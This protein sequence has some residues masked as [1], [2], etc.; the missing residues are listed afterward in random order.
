[1]NDFIYVNILNEGKIPW[2]MKQ[3]PLFYY[4]AP[5]GVYRLLARDPRVKMEITNRELSE[6][7][8]AEYLEKLNPKKEKKE[9]IAPIAEVKEEPIINSFGEEVV[10]DENDAEID[11]ILA[12]APVEMMVSDIANAPV[13][14][15]DADGMAIYTDEQLEKMTKKELKAILESRGHAAG[16]RLVKSTDPYS[17]MYHDSVDDLREKVRKSQET[18]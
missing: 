5:A 18:F 17:P 16:Q 6:K 14:Q 1:M 7:R 2:I 15:V 8:K 12:E 10:K 13:Q 4:H 11:A 9:Y 3:G